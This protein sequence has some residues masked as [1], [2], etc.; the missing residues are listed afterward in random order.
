M[1]MKKILKKIIFKLFDFL[2]LNPN[3]I[4]FESN[5]VI[6]DNS[7]NLFFYLLEKKIDSRY[8]IVW[9][10]D[11]VKKYKKAFKMHK[12]VFFIKRTPEKAYPFKCLYHSF[13][14]KYCFYT[15]VFLGHSSNK[16]QKKIFLTHGTPIKDSSGFF[17]DPYNN[18]DIISTSEFAS[19]LR[20][21][22]FGG[23]E[24][25][26]RIL[27]FPRNDSLFLPD[28]NTL[29]Y[30]NQIKKEKLIIWLP[31]FKH[32]NLKSSNRSD[33]SESVDSDISVMS[34]EFML[35]LNNKLIERDALLIIKYHPSQDLDYVPMHKYTNIISMS[36][37]DLEK[38]SVDLYS[39]LGL[40]DALITDFSSVYLDY[41]LCDKPI[42]FDL[43]D[44]QNYQEGRGFIIEDPK[45]V[46]PGKKILQQNDLIDFIFEVCDNVDCFSE[47]RNKLKLKIHKYSDNDASK[48]IVEY[49][50][51]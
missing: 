20:C 37:N 43:C 17:W 29:K 40:S 42:G 34:E 1:N 12:N 4:M 45:S 16:E 21:K 13:T 39:L 31:T 26:V 48:R 9:V 33:F 8:K 18:T 25:I 7:K 15:H 36:N 2:P 19:T 38:E 5:M 24:D 23:G 3:K 27:G 6:K 30:F 44:I 32:H 35:L 49:F 50:N 47:D 46:M 22:T 28:E 14:S 51:L 10:V 41:L 11:D